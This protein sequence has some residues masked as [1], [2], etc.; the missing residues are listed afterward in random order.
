[1]TNG[2]HVRSWDSAASDNLWTEACG[3]DL[4]MGEI[5]NLEEQIRALSD[6]KIWAMRN[7]ARKHMIEF[8]RAKL[9][10]LLAARGSPKEEVEHAKHR[11]D[12]NVLTIGFARRFATY[13]RPNM[14]LHDPDRLIRILTNKERPVQLLLAGKA[15]PAD[16]GGQALIEQ[17]MHFI[18][19]PELRSSVLFISDYDV[20]VTTN[21]VG[22][23][24]LWINTP[25]RPWEACGTSG[26]KVLVNGGL[27]LSELDGWW[28]EAYKPE[29]GWAI[30]D[31]NE[32][33]DD[34]G[35]DAH[36]ANQLYDLLE[37]EVIPSFYNRNKE[38]IP[39]SWISR[40]RE[41]MAQLTPRFSTNRSVREYTEKYYLPAAE[42]YRKRDREE[43]RIAKE[44]VKWK[45]ALD[46]NLPNLRF[47]ALK[48]ETQGN[49]H[50]FEVQV[51][52]GNLDPNGISVELF[53]NGRDRADPVVM[54]MKNTK[55][56]GQNAYL[57]SA[58]V[59]D[60]RPIGD[61]TIRAIPSFPGVAVPL[62][63]PQIIWQ[64]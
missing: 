34:W 1:M 45:S 9:S 19:R 38:G 23:V 20:S 5:E 10:K 39:T 6:A 4:W 58:E 46:E 16:Q 59:V 57:Y 25:R 36:E 54:E 42:N 8:G 31:G 60:T 12:P 56:I 18:W 62:E 55:E 27:N 2:V 11:F 63:N 14:L 52:F 17:W 28:A 49:R 24:D 32:H 48:A 7:A 29:L 26:M 40:V 37:N 3:K 33:G 21:L 50:R 44:I 13:K 61:F 47:Q 41:S 22:G 43:S 35:W 15:H 30:G 51:H 64:R 53:A